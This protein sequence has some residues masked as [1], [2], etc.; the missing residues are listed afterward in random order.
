[1]LILP[2]RDSEN[3]RTPEE[4]GEQLDVLRHLDAR[5]VVSEAIHAGDETPA[6]GDSSQRAQRRRLWLGLRLALL[7]TI[8]VV[9]IVAAWFR[10]KVPDEPFGEDEFGFATPPS[11]IGDASAADAGQAARIQAL[12]S[13]VCDWRYPTQYWLN[14]PIV[15]S[16][17][18]VY[19][20]NSFKYG[21]QQTLIALAP[22]GT[23]KWQKDN[24][25]VHFTWSAPLLGA[26]GQMIIADSRG[27]VFALD[28][29]GNQLWQLQL[30]GIVDIT[31]GPAGQVIY[32]ASRSD[33]RE[34][35]RSVLHAISADG[36][37]LWHCELPGT[38]TTSLPV[39]YFGRRQWPALVAGPDSTLYVTSVGGK[40]GEPTI[41]SAVSSVG[42]LL[43]SRELPDEHQRK[44]EM[45]IGSQRY[46]PEKYEHG[47]EPDYESGV[48]TWRTLEVDT[49][50]R[51]RCIVPAPD[52]GCYAVTRTDTPRAGKLLAFGADGALRWKADL[53]IPDYAEPIIGS[54]GTIYI[55]CVPRLATG[56]RDQVRAL[57]PADGSTRW[58]C[59]VERSGTLAL[60]ASGNLYLSTR[61]ALWAI[62]A[63]G[64]VLWTAAK[65]MYF[66]PPHIAADGSILISGDFGLAAYAP[67][68][69]ERFSLELAE[70][71]PQDFTLG[72]GGRIYMVLD[73]K[74]LVALS[75]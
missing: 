51:F 74:E 71:G 25:S 1:M 19:L 55:C 65:G 57:N 10:Y 73:D 9:L 26:E 58:S 53:G 24:P 67:D 21:T 30:S 50:D 59:P 72:P 54:D 36:K 5:D 64:M 6:E 37:V 13:Q 35:W 68:G 15:G 49:D 41:L 11:A 48:V 17:G 12:V 39:W 14:K 62:G 40:V 31:L 22:D 69:A 7:I 75:R 32:A 70:Y 18:T 27:E 60:N 16:D 43:W 20:T 28:S 42:N 63:N 46:D 38:V 52:G 61:D 56:W 33:G 29:G 8:G 66:S 2:M 47:E 44:T 3:I 4:H 34:P 23:V 45:Y